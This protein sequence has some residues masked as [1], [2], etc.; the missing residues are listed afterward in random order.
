[1]GTQMSKNIKGKENIYSPQISTLFT[2]LILVFLIAIYNL[3][4]TLIDYLLKI[5]IDF[6][7]LLLIASVFEMLLCNYS[8][9][10][11]LFQ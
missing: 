2:N 5:R 3:T 1:M 11:K 8:S 4:Y 7:L 6:P 10:Q 9:T